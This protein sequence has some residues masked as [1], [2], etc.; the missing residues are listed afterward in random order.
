VKRVSALHME[1]G[2]CAQFHDG[3]LVGTGR[4][5]AAYDGALGRMIEARS[6]GGWVRWKTVLVIQL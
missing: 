6:Q 3:Y 1:V 2:P 4:A 5:P